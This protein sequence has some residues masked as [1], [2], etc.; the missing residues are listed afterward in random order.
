MNVNT[1]LSELDDSPAYQLL[2]EEILHGSLMPG[3]RLRVAQLRTRYEL[4]LTPIREALMRLSAEGLVNAR[5]HRGASVRAANL[6]QFQDL[7]QT[8]R[9]IEAM[10]LRKAIAQGDAHWE[11]EILRSFH[12]LSR[13]ALPL[14]A[15]DR[16]TASQ[17]ETLHRQFHFSLL[18][19]CDSAWLLSFWQ[20]LSD[21]SAIYR[22]LRL[23]LQGKTKAS[24]R[25]LH[26]EHE[27]VMKAV[28]DR[29][30]EA[31]IKQMDQHLAQTEQVITRLLK[32]KE[33]R[34]TK[35]NLSKGK[36]H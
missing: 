17:W 10:C 3:E 11:A 35:S 30:P 5:S 8:R 20:T 36:E 15:Q 21:H 28:I 24:E 9:S 6:T 13:A 27:S 23:G 12:L 33:D 31:A 32:Q 34:E 14:R 4:G 19:A 16:D 29:K 2:R 1:K 18:S 26:S 25:K 22:K 7:M